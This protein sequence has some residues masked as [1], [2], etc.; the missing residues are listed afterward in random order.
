MD[1]V[2]L[3][4]ILPAIASNVTFYD[5]RFEVGLFRLDWQ[6]WL[7]CGIRRHNCVILATP[8]QGA[9]LEAMW[10]KTQAFYTRG[11]WLVPVE[12]V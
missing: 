7:K 6:A 3:F 5:I 12:H 9:Q 2:Y 1:D 4:G 8:A 11:P 10:N